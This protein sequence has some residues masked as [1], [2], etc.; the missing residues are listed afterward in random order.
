L[1]ASLTGRQR[2]PV[3]LIDLSLAG[4]LVRCES[5][6]DRGVVLDLELPLPEFTLNLKVRVVHCSVDGA[7][8]REQKTRYLTGLQFMQLAATDTAWLRSFLDVQARRKS[9]S[10]GAD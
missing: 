2:R 1:E 4:C 7:S 6:F 10:P 5:A 8:L 3:S 9:A